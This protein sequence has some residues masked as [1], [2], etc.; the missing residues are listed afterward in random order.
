MM[1]LIASKSIDLALSAWANGSTSIDLRGAC[2]SRRQCGFTLIEML[3][4]LV[5]LSLTGLVVATAVGNVAAQTWSVER[6]TVAHWVAENQLARIQL[7]RLNNPSPVT[8]GRQSE[9]VI[10]GGRRWRVRQSLTSTSHPT[11]YRVEIAVHE[12][13]GGEEVGPLSRSVSFIGRR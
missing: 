8:S 4:A 13:V 3:I 10:L 6:R 1:R 5:V 7:S 9:T 11:L 2:A 12:L